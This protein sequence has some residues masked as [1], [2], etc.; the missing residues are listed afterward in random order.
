[1]LL[2]ALAGG[3]AAATGC[4]GVETGEA[5]ANK[6]S[7][8][9]WPRRGPV[10]CVGVIATSEVEAVYK[11]E[12]EESGPA[13]GGVEVATAL[14]EAEELKRANKSLSDCMPVAAA[15]ESRLPVLVGGLAG[16]EG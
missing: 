15:A 9:A 8:K 11:L 16:P 10:D 7:S 1:M 5:I 2:F 4:A 14:V 3:L 6:L 12:R 13:G